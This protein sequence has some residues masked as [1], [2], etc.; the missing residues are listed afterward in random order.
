MKW[1]QQ[2]YD[3]N[4]SNG[5]PNGQG[6]LT[7]NDDKNDKKLQKNR[8]SG[9]WTDGQRD[10]LGI[11]YYAN[12]SQYEGFW[13]KNLKHGNAVFQDEYGNSVHHVFQNDR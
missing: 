2:E 10:G 11:F 4:W 9:H 7:W 8:Y 6:T 3:G 13:E 1:R 12:T 5:K